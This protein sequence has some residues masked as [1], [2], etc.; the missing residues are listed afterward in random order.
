MSLHWLTDRLWPTAEGPEPPFKPVER[1]IAS[2]VKKEVLTLIHTELRDELDI[3]ADRR[4][5][6]ETR[7]LAVGSLTP[8]AF[9]VM[10]GLVTFLTSGRVALFTQTS[11]FW[12]ALV[13]VYVAVQ[14]LAAT[15]AAVRGLFRRGYQ[16]ATTDE[17]VVPASQEEDYLAGRNAELSRRLDQHRHETNARLT[18]LPSTKIRSSSP[19]CSGRLLV[20]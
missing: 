16:A 1:Q 18:H 14:F 8:V 7:L 10:T 4:R 9:T 12:L 5:S 17:L 20:C 3:E 2:G 19:C 11:I 15:L 13:S 6:I